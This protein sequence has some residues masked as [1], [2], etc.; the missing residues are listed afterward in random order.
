[1]SRP[2][3]CASAERRAYLKYGLASREFGR[4]FLEVMNDQPKT[5]DRRK[6][7]IATGVPGLDAILHG[8]LLRQAVYMFRGQPG[9]GKTIL[10]NQLCFHH[11]AGGGNV[12]Y[13]TLLSETHERMLFNIGQLSFFEAS[14]I[15]DQIAYLSAYTIFEQS[16]L[17][18]LSE[19]LR[20]ETR[21][22]DASLLV[23]D[24]LVTVEEAPVD[25]ND[26][27]KFIHDMQVHA[28]MQGATVVLLS[29]AGT[30]PSGPEHTM[31]DGVIDVRDNR[32]G[33]RRE[34]EL[35]VSKFRGSDCLPGGH[36]FRI[37]ARGIEVYPRLESI[38][39]DPDPRDSV[40]L[41]Q[42]STGVPSLDVALQ[43]GLRAGS[44]S[45]L[46]GPTGS[47]KTTLGLHF[48]SAASVH[49]PALL[50][51]FYETPQRVLL[52]AKTLGLDLA[53]R[54]ADGS[55][56]L[57]WHPPTER[58]LDALGN[59]LVSAVRERGAKRL[60]VDGIDALAGA[61][62]DRDRIS[63]FF[64]ALTNELRSH[65]VTALYTQELHA[66]IEGD[67]KLP[68]ES[69]SALVENVL[70]L[71]FLE[72][73][74]RLARLFSV[75]KLRDSGHDDRTHELRIGPQGASLVP[76]TPRPLR[77]VRRLLRR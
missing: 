11:A 31:V 32:V 43:G 8:G 73:D 21:A 9:A 3:A 2:Y 64:S 41:T 39:R 69:V 77:R 74:A 44:T 4:T 63:H 6:E 35:E 55:L 29:S 7:R 46:F 60:F 49:E 14:R 20:R 48:L 75:I 70:L 54:V 24:G 61:A 62:A 40:L 51:G 72:E 28:S 30:Q 19:M 13:V 56:E 10:A 37:S 34:R 52:K 38:L 45:V 65:G 53:G 76:L 26:F 16:G 66:L 71:R 58:E 59:R 1:M 12:L 50:F 15:P 42:I 57:L 33:K 67:L 23:V 18:G 17:K 5:F 68:L 27:K 25:G 47:G 36:A 22:V